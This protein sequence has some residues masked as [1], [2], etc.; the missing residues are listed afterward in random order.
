MKK[1]LTRNGNSYAL[2]LDKPLMELLSMTPDMPMEI[3]TDGQSLLVT[4]LRPVDPA[5]T[6]AFL[7]AVNQVNTAFGP[8]LQSLAKR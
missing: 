8:M 4:P 6:R 7:E 1:N 2:T 5:R 3:R